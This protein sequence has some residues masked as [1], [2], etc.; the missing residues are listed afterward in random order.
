[1]VRSLLRS[2]LR[3]PCFAPC[4]AKKAAALANNLGT[5]RSRTIALKM[6]NGRPAFRKWDDREKEVS[7]EA[8]EAAP[9]PK[10]DEPLPGALCRR[11]PDQTFRYPAQIPAGASKIPAGRLRQPAA[12]L[13]KKS[14]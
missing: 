9:S 10:L 2:L 12:R 4:A 14:L 6:H 8:W 11:S 13:P 1:M 3:S 5:T 7:E